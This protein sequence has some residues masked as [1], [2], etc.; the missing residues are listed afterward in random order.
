MPGRRSAAAAVA[1]DD[2][3]VEDHLVFV[4]LREREHAPRQINPCG[5]AE[6]G[7]ERAVLRGSSEVADAEDD[8]VEVVGE[9]FRP[10]I[11]NRTAPSLSVSVPPRW[12]PTGRG[13][14]SRRAD[15]LGASPAR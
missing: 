7:G 12:F 1:G 3:D 11:A 15:L 13:R 8:A 4:V 14:S 6:H 5:R 10:A 9:R 2:L